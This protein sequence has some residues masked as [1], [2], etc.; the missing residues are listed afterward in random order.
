[1][2]IRY[3][4]FRSGIQAVGLR[5]DDRP[6]KTRGREDHMVDD[7]AIVPVVALDEA[8]TDGDLNVQGTGGV[9]KDMDAL[10]GC[11]DA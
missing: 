11:R 8:L 7:S 5:A 4:K 3:E 10:T 1:M 2:G 9:G 6:V